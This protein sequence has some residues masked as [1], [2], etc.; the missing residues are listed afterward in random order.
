MINKV[1]LLGHLGADPDTKTLTN[2]S[3][4]SNVN[5]ATSRNWTN[6]DGSKG[7]RTDWHRLVAWRKASEILSMAHK[8]SK[9]YIEGELQHRS[10]EGQDGEKKYITEV[11]VGTIRLLDPKNGN[12]NGSGNGVPHSAEIS[13][14]DTTFDVDKLEELPDVDFA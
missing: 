3:Q 1:I 4:V 2:G 6:K 14:E 9:I 13:T 8:G 12:G 7:E 10:Y 5:L 11:E